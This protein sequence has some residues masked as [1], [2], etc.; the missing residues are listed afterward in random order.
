MQDFK[1]INSIAFVREQNNNNNKTHKNIK[2]FV[3]A[4]KVN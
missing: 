4:R 2:G 1:D 3:K